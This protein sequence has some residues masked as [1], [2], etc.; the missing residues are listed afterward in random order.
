VTNSTRFNFSNG[1]ALPRFI[2]LLE[3]PSLLQPARREKG[4]AWR[5]PNFWR[6]GS[7]HFASWLA[8]LVPRFGWKFASPV[9]EVPMLPRGFH[10]PFQQY[11]PRCNFAC[12]V[13]C[14]AF[15][16]CGSPVGARAFLVVENVL[17]CVLRDPVT[18]A[19]AEYVF[20][21]VWQTIQKPL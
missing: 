4:P 13:S 7:L 17:S 18:R 2:P 1:T 15:P 14:F 8:R 11:L 6:W 9:R 5:H 12:F 16:R 19:D 3:A 10:P 20:L 21:D